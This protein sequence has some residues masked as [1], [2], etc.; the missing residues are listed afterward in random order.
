MKRLFYPAVILLATTSLEAAPRSFTSVDGKT[1]SAELVSAD[2]LQ[3]TL[4]LADGRETVV[5]LNR[6]SAA[7]QAFIVSWMSSSP[8]AIRYNFLVDATKEKVNSTETSDVDTTTTTTQWLYHVKVTNR[9]SQPVEGLKVAYQIHY[10]DADGKAKSAEV[11]HGAKQLPAL[12]PG[13]SASVDTEAVRL[14]STRLNSGYIYRDGGPARQTDTLKG[15]AVTIMHNGKSVHE[16][17]SGTS[18]KK[19]PVS[20]APAKPKASR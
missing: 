1:V 6:L 14:I 9:A 18:V 10:S 5:P 13:E 16:F 15:I 7:D 4:K 12:K 11:Q 2:G 17:T 19:V 8:Q 20:N 3:A